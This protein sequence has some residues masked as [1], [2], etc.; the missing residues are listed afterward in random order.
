MEMPDL[1]GAKLWARRQFVRLI[2]VG[3]L[4]GGAYLFLEIGDGPRPRQAKVA[5]LV[6]GGTFL[7]SWVPA[8]RV[9]AWLR[10]VHRVW[11]LEL[12][13]S[14]TGVRLWSLT[15]GAWRDLEVVEGELQQLRCAVEC[16]EVRSFDPDEL[17]AVGTWRASKTPLEL[18]RREEAIEDLRGDLEELAREGL[19]MRV[20]M[21]TLVRDATIQVV[22][23]FVE[24]FERGVIP[25]G[26]AI[27]EVVADALD[28]ELDDDESEPGPPDE[29]LLQLEDEP[30]A[31]ADGGDP[32]A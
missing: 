26:E 28:D 18:A 29:E 32:G 22:G 14:E 19:T 21:S 8:S 10:S 6:F 31:A 5:Y 9:V 30:E 2:A 27:Q 24:T 23:T 16:Y 11:I 20:R 17:E 3:Y 1:E 15:P 12:G 13:D 7:L 25:D 4:G